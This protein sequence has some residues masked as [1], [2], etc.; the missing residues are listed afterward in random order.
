MHRAGSFVAQ[1]SKIVRC[2][3][4]FA[5][6][7][8]LKLRAAVP[9]RS[10]VLRL[11]AVVLLAAPLSALVVA[12]E[13]SVGWSSVPAILARVNPPQFPDRDFNVADYGAVADLFDIAEEL[14]QRFGS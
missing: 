8:W 6:Q 11:A 5:R 4:R 9:V 1:T 3:T 12:D 13:A 10:V 14:E 7:A 2:T